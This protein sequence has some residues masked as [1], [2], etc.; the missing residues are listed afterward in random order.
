[1]AMTTRLWTLNALATELG[2]SSRVLGK[3]LSSLK[4]D[5]VEQ[6]AGRQVKRWRLARAL[7]HLKA[8]DPT[9]AGSSGEKADTERARLTRARVR[10][11]EIENCRPRTFPTPVR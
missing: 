5:D 9:T 2:I 4:P 10:K 3:R 1:M 11:A 8:A 7:K 6:Q